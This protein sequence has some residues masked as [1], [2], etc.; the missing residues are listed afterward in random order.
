VYKHITK[1]DSG[2]TRGGAGRTT[3]GDTLQRGDAGA[4]LEE[5]I[6]GAKQKVDD[7]F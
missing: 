7:L 5:N 6:W 4:V 1:P 2:V 3:P